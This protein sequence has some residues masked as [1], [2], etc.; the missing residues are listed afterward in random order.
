M[1]EDEDDGNLFGEINKLRKPELEDDDLFDSQERDKLNNTIFAT[2]ATHRYFEATTLVIIT[3][4]ALYIGLDA[5][6]TARGLKGDNLYGEDDKGLETPVFF[7]ICENFFATYFTIEV[8]IRFLSLRQHKFVEFWCISCDSTLMWLRFDSFLVAV[9]IVETWILPAFNISGG[10]SALSVLRLARLLRLVKLL[11]FIPEL[12]IIV[13]GMVASIR[14]VASTG[15]LQVGLL[16]VFGILFTNVYHQG[17][18]SDE[19]VAENG[20]DSAVLFGGMGK[21]M[22]TLFI[23]GTILDDVT[24]GT[25]TIRSSKNGT[26]MLLVFL[27]FILV[28][29]FTILNMLIGILCEVV[30][31]TSEGE[32]AKT[33]EMNAKTSVTQLFNK[34]DRDR[35]GQITRDEFMSMRKNTKVR[36]ALRNLDIQ[37]KHFETYAEL[38]FPD[39]EDPSTEPQPTFDYNR[40]MMM[41]M[42]LRPGTS[43]SAL[44]FASFKN[45]VLKNSDNLKN[46]VSSVERKVHVLQHYISGGSMIQPLAEISASSTPEPT[47]E[48]MQIVSP[49]SL[50][51]AKI[52][53]STLPELDRT[54]DAEILEELQ[55][56]VVQRLP[57]DPGLADKVAEDA[58][59]TLGVP[60]GGVPHAWRPLE[61]SSTMS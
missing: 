1:N 21:S 50:S 25:N 61:E 14:S 26:V 43:M 52:T 38:L 18:R 30:A 9:M 2:I 13:K 15:A 7:A 8:A 57:P 29:S 17:N 10:L 22:R 16:Y 28:S 36:E 4:N 5:E 47:P 46:Q 44:D 45:E 33:A 40:L 58:F 54:S 42:R 39:P 11:R 3:I 6:Y 34:L 31:A 56:R 55:R 48:L 49:K 32:Q 35:D 27:F 37:Q 53:V 59:G 51:P 23:M 60:L 24:A 41:V 19:D 20:P 12:Q